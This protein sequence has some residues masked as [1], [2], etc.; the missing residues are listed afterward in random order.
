MPKNIDIQDKRATVAYSATELFLKKGYSKLTVSEVAQNAG[1]A[2]GSIYKYFDIL[3]SML[4]KKYEDLLHYKKLLNL[5]TLE[6]KTYVA[7]LEL[8]PTF[9]KTLTTYTNIPTSKLYSIVKSLCEKDFITIF[10][11][12]DKR[13]YVAKNPEYI[14]DIFKEEERNLETII[15]KLKPKQQNEEE[16]ISIYAGIKGIKRFYKF[17]IDNAKPKEILIL[18][19]NRFVQEK[20][21]LF[22]KTWNVKRVDKKINL[23]IMYT[24]STKKIL[25]FVK[26]LDYTE[27]KLLP[28]DITISSWMDV[29]DDYVAFFDITDNIKAYV[30]KNK[31]IAN[32]QRKY[33]Y[34]LWNKL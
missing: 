19:A 25:N 31:D 13:K 24:N 16:F 33:F 30:I 21:E 28:D 23:K 8:G 3:Y 20:M 22:I 9:M 4:N 17:I 11:E 29:F 27:I 1:I 5:N 14:L 32:S 7:L 26:N 2:K 15:S 10:L 12:N 18:G 6:I 34:Y